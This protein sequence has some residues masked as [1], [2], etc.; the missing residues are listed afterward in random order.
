MVLSGEAQCSRQI[1]TVS[2]NEGSVIACEKPHYPMVWSVPW[3]LSFVFTIRV[4]SH[5]L[6]IFF[7]FFLVAGSD[8]K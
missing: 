4:P 6:L 3:K 8:K 1:V 5:C 2:N 7:F